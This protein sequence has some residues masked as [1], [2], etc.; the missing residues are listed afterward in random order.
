[1]WSCE[2]RVLQVPVS[3]PPS[4]DDDGLSEA[5]PAQSFNPASASSSDPSKTAGDAF[6]RRSTASSSG[7]SD[8]SSALGV[9]HAALKGMWQ[10][11]DI[12]AF[13]H[14]PDMPPDLRVTHL[15]ATRP[16]A[17]QPTAPSWGRRLR[18]VHGSFGG[19]VEGMAANIAAFL[20]VAAA[21]AGCTLRLK[22][23]R[24]NQVLPV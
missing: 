10:R 22:Q 12:Q 13:L 2:S 19:H 15:P 24:S 11:A 6:M 9:Q 16:S 4:A 17:L 1:M 21:I 14:Q 5:G 20:R 8:S 18:A 7:G 23:I 3:F